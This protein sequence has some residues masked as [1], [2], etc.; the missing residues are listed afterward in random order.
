[1]TKV[2]IQKH[3]GSIVSVECDGH[4]GYGVEGEDIV[5]SALS[6]IVQTAALGL[7]QVAGI[8]LDYEVREE[9]GY[10]KFTLPPLSKERRRDANMILNTLYLGIFDLHEGFSDFI[11]LEVK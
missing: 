5:C 10:L 3:N 7:M 11:E 2:R 9:D 4:T 1:M 8:D 6:S